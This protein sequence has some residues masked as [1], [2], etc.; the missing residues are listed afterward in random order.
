MG[1]VFLSIFVC[2]EINFTNLRG[3][4]GCGALV[5]SPVYPLCLAYAYDFGFSE[6]DHAC[7]CFAYKK[8]FT[9]LG[10]TI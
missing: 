1:I 5:L 7:K 2:L 8:A 10:N 4:L 9:Q 6:P 3:V